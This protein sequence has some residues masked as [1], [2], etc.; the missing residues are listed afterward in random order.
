MWYKFYA[1]PKGHWIGWIEGINGR[2][3]GFIKNDETVQFG[4]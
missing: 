4:W 3:I 2:C 1:T